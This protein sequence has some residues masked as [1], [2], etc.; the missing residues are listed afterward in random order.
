MRT[1]GQAYSEVKMLGRAGPAK[2]RSRMRRAGYLVLLLVAC[3]PAA[4]S[5][6]VAAA[7]TTA[8]LAEVGPRVGAP[9]AG[10]LAEVG[11]SAP[12]EPR[13]E[14][15]VVDPALADRHPSLAYYPSLAA[16]LP[17]ALFGGGPREILAALVAS[18]A[19]YRWPS[20]LDWDRHGFIDLHGPRPGFVTRVSGALIS[21]P[22]DR[23]DLGCAGGFLEGV[24]LTL[25]PDLAIGELDRCD[26][27]ADAVAGG[28]TACEP[29]RDYGWLALRNIAVRLRPSQLPVGPRLITLAPER[30]EDLDRLSAAGAMH[31]CTVSHEAN[32]RGRLR[33][34]HHMM[35]VLARGESDA[36]D[37]FDTT[38]I[39][40]VALARMTR[41]R[42]A[43]YVS[44]QL[45]AS[46]EFRYARSSAQLICLPVAAR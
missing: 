20:A 6:T 15:V 30:A 18:M 44:V 24:R 38:G 22:G 13:S 3:E 36:F 17:A 11:P 42:F 10:T 25:V 33:L 40:G 2:T 39:R 37:V 41:A 31:L 21:Q 7:P 19:P 27:A 35:I 34:H 9:V 4:P 16:A 29:Q 43:E 32:A 26:V 5:Q 14:P 12:A 8:T 1:L 23:H 28:P 45:A 46:R